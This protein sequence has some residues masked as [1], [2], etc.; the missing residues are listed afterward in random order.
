MFFSGAAK[1]RDAG[2]RVSAS[3]AGDTAG[4]TESGKAG[5]EKARSRVPYTGSAIYEHV[6]RYI[7]FL[8]Y[9]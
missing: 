1:D 8:T 2:P 5:T 7:G 9:P 6:A 4:C 3:N